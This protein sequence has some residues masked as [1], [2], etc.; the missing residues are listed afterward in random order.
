MSK[1]Q[2]FSN[3]QSLENE[4]EDEI[5]IFCILYNARKNKYRV[6]HA[7]SVFVDNLIT[8]CTFKDGIRKIVETARVCGEKIEKDFVKEE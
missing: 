6:T 5:R 2:Q 1:K 7:D 4:T 8:D 3:P